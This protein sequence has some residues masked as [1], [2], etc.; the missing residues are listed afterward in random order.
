MVG[1]DH[2]VPEDFVLWFVGWWVGGW[3]IKSVRIA[4]RESVFASQVT[5]AAAAAA[6]PSFLF[7]SNRQEAKSNDH[8]DDLSRR[9]LDRVGRNATVISIP[10]GDDELVFGKS[11]RGLLGSRRRSLLTHR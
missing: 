8:H 1:R 7:S 4:F 5:A 6:L 9:R 2:D 11:S 3:L 10:C